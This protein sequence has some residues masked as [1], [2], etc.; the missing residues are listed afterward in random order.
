MPSPPII[1]IPTTAGTGSETNGAAVVTDD[2]THKKLYFSHNDGRA[3]TVILDAELTVGMPRYPTASCGMD[4]LTHALE[5]YTS[6]KAN[7][8]TDALGIGAIRLVVK[9]LPR[10]MAD[11][12]DLHARGQ[13]QIASFMAASAFD[14]SG[15]GLMHATGHQITS[16]YGVPH[17]QTLA[18]VLPH[19]MARCAF[20][21]RSLHSRRCHWCTPC[22]LSLR[23]TNGIPLSAHSSYWLAL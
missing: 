13:M 16:L 7:P 23:A 19:V 12:T 2:A 3:A 10:V 18:T 20:F 11:L 9:W 22:S 4:V 14:S 8:F 5:A 17:G 6:N 15:L 1:A 21:D